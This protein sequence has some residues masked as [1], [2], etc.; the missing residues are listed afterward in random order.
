MIKVISELFPE[1]KA[2][3]EVQN[4][5]IAEAQRIIEDAEAE[6]Q[7]IDDQLITL[8]TMK[9]E[10]G[11]EATQEIEKMEGA[12]SIGKMISELIKSRAAMW[13]VQDEII[14]EV[15]R[16]IA[17][18]I[19]RKQ[20]ISDQLKTLEI[21]IVAPNR[22]A[23]DNWTISCQELDMQIDRMG[24]VKCWNKGEPISDDWDGLNDN[25]WRI[26][27]DIDPERR[28]KYLSEL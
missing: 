5:I 4:E 9:D 18:A 6:K 10:L 14:A 16:I 23:L 21:T 7:T 12:E 27:E 26:L 22:D 13:E 19:A 15:Q 1:L 2:G 17:E 20:T 8:E 11:D 24:R 28:A 3:R 25:Q